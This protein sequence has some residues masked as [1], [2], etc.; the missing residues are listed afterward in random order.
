[1]L[2]HLATTTPSRLSD[3][4]RVDN[5]VNDA[6]ATRMEV[7][8]LSFDSKDAR[9][10]SWNCSAPPSLHGRSG[11]RARGMA[12]PHDDDGLE[13]DTWTARRAEGGRDVTRGVSTSQ[14]VR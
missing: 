5:R 12:L 8:V 4:L 13:S 14:H 10:L 2:L 9:K 11:Q 6:H 1:M 7:R 3:T